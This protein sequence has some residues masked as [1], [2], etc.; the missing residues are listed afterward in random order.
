M[1]LL[2]LLSTKEEAA[3]TRAVS[4]HAPVLLLSLLPRGAS[5]RTHKVAVACSEC[6]AFHRCCRVQ[7]PLSLSAQ[8][9]PLQAPASSSAGRRIGSGMRRRRYR[10]PIHDYTAALPP[11]TAILPQALIF[12]PRRRASSNRRG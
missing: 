4:T 11:D 10:L 2:L 7:P 12:F 9:L 3:T 8:S 1:L 5:V 6:D